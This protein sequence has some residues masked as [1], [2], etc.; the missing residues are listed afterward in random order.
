MPNNDDDDNNNNNNNTEYFQSDKEK[1]RQF[2]VKDTF[3]KDLFFSLLG[4]FSVMLRE[5]LLRKLVY[6]SQAVKRK[7]IVHL[8]C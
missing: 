1:L 2:L 6:P 8:V 7:Q 3:P 5:N 4:M